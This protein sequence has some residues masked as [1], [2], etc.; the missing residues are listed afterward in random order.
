MDYGTVSYNGKT[1]TLDA[2]AELSNRV[3][4]GWWGDRE[5]N[6]GSYIDEWKAPAHD[7][8]GNNYDVYWQ[9]ARTAGDEIQDDELPWNDDHISEV[10]QQ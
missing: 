5:E 3:F 8:D 7:A 2:Q 1:L 9:F 4:C 6:C 10:T